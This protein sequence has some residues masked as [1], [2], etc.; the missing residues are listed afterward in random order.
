VSELARFFDDVP[1][2]DDRGF[3]DAVLARVERMERRRR[4]GEWVLRAGLVLAS[5]ALAPVAATLLRELGDA[6]EVSLPGMPGSAVFAC[7]GVGASA[8]VWMARPPARA[9]G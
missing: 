1:P 3:T 5:A 8:L 6:L 9:R 4:A 7:L 2:P